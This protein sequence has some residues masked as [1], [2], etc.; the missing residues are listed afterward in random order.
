MPAIVIIMA[1]VYIVLFLIISFATGIPSAAHILS[2]LHG[3]SFTESLEEHT[4]YWWFYG[5]AFLIGSV[6][7]VMLMQI[8]EALSRIMYGYSVLGPST[9][10]SMGKYADGAPHVIPR[11]ANY[12][13][14]TAQAVNP[15]N[16]AVPNAPM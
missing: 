6:Q 15:P 12:V 4:K 7:T 14:Q 1:I 16:F 9:W 3:T 10:L 5:M 2:V 11:P 8:T 13:E